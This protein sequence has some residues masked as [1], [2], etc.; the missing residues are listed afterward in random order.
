MT[1]PL[2]HAWLTAGLFLL[3]LVTAAALTRVSAPYGRHVRDGW[4]PA[5]P[6]RWVWMLM[7]S[8]AVLARIS[9]GTP[10]Q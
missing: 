7:E 8:P 6:S 10:L 5:L 2:L 1:E 9:S 3:A 4:G